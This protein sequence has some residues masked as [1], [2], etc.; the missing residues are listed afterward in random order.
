[1]YTLGTCSF[2]MVVFFLT[3]VYPPPPQAFAWTSSLVQ[4]GS[5]KCFSIV[6]LMG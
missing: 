6:L 2:G 5:E 4:V 1:M 3:S